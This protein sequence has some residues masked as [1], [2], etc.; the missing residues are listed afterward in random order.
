MSYGA[1]TAAPLLVLATVVAALVLAGASS[2]TSKRSPPPAVE[3]VE[4][5]P[6]YRC[7]NGICMLYDAQ[8]SAQLAATPIDFGAPPT[9]SAPEGRLVPIVRVA[10]LKAKTPPDDFHPEILRL[11]PV[12]PSAPAVADYYFAEADPATATIA[13]PTT[14]TP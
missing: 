1:R 11:P 12:D 6:T 8:P 13:Y 14:A 9:A 2:C 3:K 10:D 7:E 5:V 4:P